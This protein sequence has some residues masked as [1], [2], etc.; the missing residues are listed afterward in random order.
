MKKLIASTVVALSLST[1]SSPAVGS[2]HAV[3]KPQIVK[4]SV[5]NSFLATVKVRNVTQKL[6]R[7]V[8]RL[9]TRVHK[10]WYVFSGATPSGWDCSGMTMW[11]YKQ[12]GV[13]LEH[14]ASLQQT[15]GDATTKP[16]L[17]DIVVF[18]YKGSKSAYHV[19]I[20]L[21]PDKMIHAGGGKGDYTSIVSI[22]K[23]AGN[24]SIVTYRRIIQ[25]I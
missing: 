3:T 6:D 23:F 9:K 1:C 20:Y 25:T 12:L 4:E 10:T 2:V 13:H 7:A 8:D 19:G 14:R 21:G 15:A 18:T 5:S 17:G 22:S 16:K 24:Y 11:M